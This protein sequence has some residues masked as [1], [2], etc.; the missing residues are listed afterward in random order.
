MFPLHDISELIP[1]F[2]QIMTADRLFFIQFAHEVSKVSYLQSVD[3][4]ENENVGGRD[5]ISDDVM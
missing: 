5:V 2:A 4:W 1:G 3:T